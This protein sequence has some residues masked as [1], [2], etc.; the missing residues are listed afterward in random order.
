MPP[1][2]TTHW[3][4]GLS[5]PVS[6]RLRYDVLSLATWLGDGFAVLAKALDVQRNRLTHQ[7]DDLLGRV[8]SGH[9]ARKVG[10]VARIRPRLPLDDDQISRVPHHF[11]SCKPAWRRTLASVPGFT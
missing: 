3:D 1:A 4:P 8:T 7:L 5:H 9:A 2:T 6:T 10:A 11:R